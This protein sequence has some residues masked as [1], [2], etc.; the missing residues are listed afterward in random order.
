MRLPSYPKVYALGHAAILDIFKDVVV[1]EE[2]VDG[3]QW[4]FS[5]AKGEISCRSKG[6]DMSDGNH[7]KMFDL[8]VQNVNEIAG[9]L[10][11]GWVYRSEYLMKPKHNTIRYAS[12]PP[13]NMIIY[14]ISP[15]LEQY[16][17]P[18]EKAEEAYRLG[19]K[20]VPIF[21]SGRCESFDQFKSLLETESCL[22]GHKIEGL[23]VKNYSRFTNDGKAMMGKFVCEVFKEE[24][25]KDFRARNPVQGDILEVLQK[26]YTTQARWR[27]AVQH[28]RESGDL[29]GT[30]KDISPLI[31]EVIKDIHEECEEDIKEKL[32]AWAWEKIKRK[33]TYGMPEWY[34]QELAK[35]AFEER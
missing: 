16:L 11:E 6:K 20:T 33:L 24:N 3:S 12:V 15:G 28:L 25:R 19:L 30:P 10:H 2:K 31:K 13:R 1:I 32:F 29:T 18:E 27:K 23:V 4:S 34:K 7:D 9:Q 26:Q 5:V 35:Q 17:S 14:D 8:A 21:F 22:G